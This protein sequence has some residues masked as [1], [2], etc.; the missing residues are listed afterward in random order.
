G[1]PTGG[2]TMRKVH[3]LAATTG[4]VLI[5][6]LVWHSRGLALAQEKPALISPAKMGVQGGIREHSCCLPGGKEIQQARRPGLGIV[7]HRKKRRKGGNNLRY[8]QAT[9]ALKCSRQ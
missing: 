2:F 5:L 9:K 8:L 6:A 4:L 7:C 3:A 1:K